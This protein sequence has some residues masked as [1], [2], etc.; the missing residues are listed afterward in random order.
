MTAAYLADTDVL[1]LGR[2]DHEPLASETIGPIVDLIGSL[3]ERGAPTRRGGDVYFRVR[4]DAGYGTLSHRDVDADGPGR[5]RGRAP[6]ARRTRCDF[7]LWKAEKPG[8]DTAWDSPW[9]RGRPGW[10]IE[11]SAMAEELLG[12]EFDIHGGG[13][14]PRLPAPRERGGPDPAAAA[15]A[16][17]RRCGCTTGC[18][19]SAARRWPSR[20]A[21]SSGSHDAVERWGRDTLVWFFVCGH[22]RQPIQYSDET[23]TASRNAVAGLRDFARAPVAGPLRTPSLEPIRD[24]FFDALADD[25]NTPAALAQLHA[26]V[27]AG[28]RARRDRRR[29][30][31]ARCSRSWGWRTCSTRGREPGRRGPRAAR[32]APG[33]PRREGLRRGR[34]AARRAAG[35]RLGGPR[36]RRRAPSSSRASRERRRRSVALRPQPGRTRRCGPGGAAVH[37]VWATSAGAAQG[38]LRSRARAWTSWAPDEVGRREL[39]ARDAHQGVVRRGRPLSVRGRRRAPRAPGARSSSPSTR[40]RTRRTSARSPAPP[41]RPGPPGSSSPSAARPR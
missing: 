10:H 34:P 18:S 40:S 27:R 3:I 38:G 29:A 32:A 36:R 22:Y 2:P 37:R 15:G 30:T 41:R 39:P 21:T 4:S 31:C 13:Q 25:F 35:P 24:A 8:E 17:S 6:S 20:S 5:G 1:G 33:R 16:S 9:G 14:R 11:C 28:A 26:W 7:A 12:V 19:S 23:L